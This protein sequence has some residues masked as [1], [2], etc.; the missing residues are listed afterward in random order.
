MPAS[1]GYDALAVCAP[2]DNQ[3]TLCLPDTSNSPAALPP[4]ISYYSFPIS[5]IYITFLFFQK[6]DLSLTVISWIAEVGDTRFRLSEL[7]NL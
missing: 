7:K 3:I 2:D 5:A 4:L 6:P 1:A